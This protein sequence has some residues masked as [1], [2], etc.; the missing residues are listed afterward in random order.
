VLWPGIVLK[1]YE[2]GGGQAVITRSKIDQ[3]SMGTSSA[4]SP[5]SVAA[6]VVNSE[7]HTGA[8]PSVRVYVKLMNETILGYFIAS[9][10]SYVSI[11]AKYFTSV[12]C[13]YYPYKNNK[14]FADWTSR[15]ASA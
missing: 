14:I 11:K 8:A 15:C 2:G 10:A 9:P 7:P 5:C 6:F 1:D 3:F 13:N 12:L 4:K